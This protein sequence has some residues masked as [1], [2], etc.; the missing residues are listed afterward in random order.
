MEGIKSLDRKRGGVFTTSGDWIRVRINVRRV[1]KLQ[2]E[3]EARVPGAQPLHQT[4]MMEIRSYK[5]Y[6][7]I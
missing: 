3:K 1:M 5:I 4:E 6:R 2:K 7:S